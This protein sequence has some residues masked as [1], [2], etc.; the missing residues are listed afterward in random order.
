MEKFLKQV[1]NNCGNPTIPDYELE[2]E[3]DKH[4]KKEWEEWVK[5]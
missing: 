3:I 1:Y 5:R 2:K 4:W